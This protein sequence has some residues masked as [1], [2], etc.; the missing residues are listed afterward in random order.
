MTPL[1][2]KHDGTT[3]VTFIFTLEIF[4]TVR[5]IL[6]THLYITINISL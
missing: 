3:L 6:V 1:I 2:A 5:Y 4:N